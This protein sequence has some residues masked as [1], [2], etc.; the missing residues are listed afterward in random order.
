MNRWLN[1]AANLFLMLLC[2]ACLLR[3][4]QVSFHLTVEVK[5]YAWLALLCTLMWAAVFIRRCFFPGISAAVGVMWYL[6]RC[7]V[8]ELPQ[9]LQDILLAVRSFWS[10]DFW[11][12][13]GGT[14]FQASAEDHTLALLM[15]MFIAVV[16]LAM[17]LSGKS[18]RIS[19]GLLLTLPVV[20]L[21]LAVNKE[22]P[23]LPLLGM[24]LFWV[25]LII[26]GDGY[27]PSNAAGRAVVLTL[28]PCLAVLGVSL[29][30][31]S[32][33]DYVPE[34]KALKLAQ[35]FEQLSSSISSFW[36]SRPKTLPLFHGAGFQSDALSGWDQGQ[37][38]LDLTRPYD[39]SA[40]AHEVF[41]FRG[42]ADGSLYL[43]GRSLGSYTGSGWDKAEE[44]S[45]SQALNYTAYAVAAAA[46]VGS[47]TVLTSSFEIEADR[48]Y[49]TLYLPYFTVCESSG[50]TLVP[51]EGIISYS[52]QNL[53]LTGGSF[54]PLPDDLQQEE[55]AYR[56]YVRDYYT[57]LPEKTRAA[58]AG[59]AR[60]NGLNA[61]DGDIL[62]KVVD[63]VCQGSIYDLG[64]GPYPDNDYALYFLQS[65]RRGYCIHYATAAC[66][67]YRALG[68]PARLC[69]GF[70]ITA[71]AGSETIVRAADAHA[72]VE[73]WL[74]GTG[75]VPVEVTYGTSITEDGSADPSIAETENTQPY[76]FSDQASLPE[77]QESGI[78]DTQAEIGLDSSGSGSAET[79][80]AGGAGVG[81]A[82][83]S[84]ENADAKNDEA[85]HSP[86]D[87]E[88]QKQT[89]EQEDEHDSVPEEE[90][91]FF[92][93]HRILLTALG[94]SAAGALAAVGRCLMLRKRLSRWLSEPDGR[95][96]AV[97]LY[98]Q[99]QRVIRFG[100]EMPEAVLTAAEKASF[101]PH[102]IS[103]EEL[104]WSLEALNELTARVQADLNP[105]RKLVFCCLLGLP[106]RP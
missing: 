94:V 72:W 104:S 69:E 73:I 101:S 83:S 34:D 29:L 93:K 48:P 55:L 70:L 39:F 80:E 4:I 45:D 12:E 60:Q 38:T 75:W 22:A 49:D 46:S 20:A 79:R 90:H 32:P 5:A 76:G 86:S 16:Y 21:C 31:N 43:R 24:C 52:G 7:G 89:D 19:M 64:V 13:S 58:L 78:T 59:I 56:S 54:G 82:A 67:L 26:S 27:R 88:R 37:D 42:S 25:E 77:N 87:D 63:Y 17:V 106:I 84:S 11:N 51:S 40:R 28:L 47:G 85:A 8:E 92:R 50:D 6:F 61:A 95:L 53:L 105:L 66:C 98:R 3:L 15:I 91:G 1:R 96:R 65:A 99:A 44:L 100:G 2:S 81:A 57:R 68:I 35:R 103:D 74:D 9:E 36:S 23:A 10:G 41:T 33:S 102:I 18:V 30:F 14:A 97:Y 62:A 71:H